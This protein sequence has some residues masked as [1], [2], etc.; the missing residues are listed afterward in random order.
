MLAASTTDSGKG[1][2]DWRLDEHARRRGNSRNKGEGGHGA[3]AK[4]K[5]GDAAEAE[6]QATDSSDEATNRKR[7]PPAEPHHHHTLT[8]RSH[9]TYSIP[10]LPLSS[11]PSEPAP[12]L[13][14]HLVVG[15]NEVTRALETRIRW[16]RWELGDRAAAPPA[17][18]PAAAPAP[19]TAQR[20]HRRRH[21]VPR[22]AEAGTGPAVIPAAA[23]RAPQLPLPLANH[24]AYAFVRRRPPAISRDTRP[25]YVVAR[26]GEGEGEGEGVRLLVNSEARRLKRLPPRGEAGTGEKGARA[27]PGLLVPTQPAAAD[28]AADGD[29]P[30][31]T[32][33]PSASA[34][35]R[36][37]APTVPLIDLVVVCRP[38]INPPSLVAHL[39]T[40][41]AAANGVHS[42][43]EGVLAGAGAGVGAGEVKGEGQA[44]E[45]EVE[46]GEGKG[47]AKRPEMRPVRLVQLDVGAERKLADALGLRRVAAIGL[48]VRSLTALP[49]L[50]LRA[51]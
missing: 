37:P 31:Q 48:S 11:E 44:M 21:K 45:V 20:G 32:D 46:E 5:D 4:V 19:D 6:V 30:M 39:P 13:L 33:E 15:I 27:G 12:P 40:M 36:P 47:G 42:A 9:S 18:P 8:T 3:K 2:A 22:A 14:S 34:P 25:P 7:N 35:A 51:C 10:S 38:D 23:A 49:L 50:A 29:A 16:G 26:E 24:P 17:S 28:D 43:L 1:I 41:V